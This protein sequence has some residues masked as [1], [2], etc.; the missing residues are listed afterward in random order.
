MKIISEITGKTYPTVDACIKAEADFTAAQKKAEE[1]RLLAQKKAEQERV[2]KEKAR[3]ERAKEVEEA[4]KAA[5]AVRQNCHKMMNEADKKYQDLLRAF[6]KDYK[7]F[8]FT[9]QSDGPLSF[10]SI[11][12]LFDLFNF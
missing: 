7:Q 1:E 9:V 11:P 4:Y 10:P 12:M 6:L 8:H 5:I 2:A 3:G